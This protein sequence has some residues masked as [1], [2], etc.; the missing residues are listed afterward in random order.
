MQF[1]RRRLLAS[2]DT[3]AAFA[4]MASISPNAWSVTTARAS[5]RHLARVKPK[6][7]MKYLFG[8]AGRTLIPLN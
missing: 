8:K 5:L 6:S 3:V 4:V 7:E 1:S 2:S